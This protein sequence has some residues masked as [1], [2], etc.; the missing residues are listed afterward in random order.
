[1]ILT[2]N[3]IR[4]LILREMKSLLEVDESI[5]SESQFL[6][7]EIDYFLMSASQPLKRSVKKV[8]IDSSR[9]EIVVYL[10]PGKSRPATDRQVACALKNKINNLD[11]QRKWILN[12]CTYDDESDED[13]IMI[14]GL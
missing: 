1:M 12:P 8:E 7:R 5:S 3:D 9:G 13:Y 2:R 11:L 14:V 10:Y 4:K 6:G